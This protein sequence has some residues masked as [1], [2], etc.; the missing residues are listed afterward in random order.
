MGRH[1]SKVSGIPTI[2]VWCADEEKKILAACLSPKQLLRYEKMM[3]KRGY[4]TIEDEHAFVYRLV[5]ED[6]KSPGH[7]RIFQKKPKCSIG[8]TGIAIG[9]DEEWAS[10]VI[11]GNPILV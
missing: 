5:G 4:K 2:N 7:I 3:E 6:V 1:V 9:I 8:I 10:Y 11:E